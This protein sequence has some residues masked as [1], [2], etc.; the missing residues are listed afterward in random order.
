[1]AYFAVNLWKLSW[2]I[3]FLGSQNG[4]ITPYG[5]KLGQICLVKNWFFKFFAIILEFCGSG[6]GITMGS[7]RPSI[8]PILGVLLKGLLAFYSFYV[9]NTVCGSKFGQI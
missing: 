6:L 3:H 1:M 4:K 5:G 7:E 9:Q 8:S 2:D